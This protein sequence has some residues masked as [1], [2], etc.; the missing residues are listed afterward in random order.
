MAPLIVGYLAPSLDTTISAIGS[1]VWLLARYPAQWAAL[2]SHPALVPN[3]FNETL[4]LESP[5]RAFSRVTTVTARAGDVDIP[6]GARVVVLYASAN[7]DKRH[8]PHPDEF[9]IT[10]PNAGEH[11]GFG[12]GVHGCAGQGLARMEAHALL[13]ALAEQIDRIDLTAPATAV[14]NNL[15]NARASVPVTVTGTNHRHR[16]RRRPGSGPDALISP[17]TP[18]VGCCARPGYAG[19][20]G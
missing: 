20:G 1:A 5:L 15:I 14:L 9:D 4:R 6:A 18:P 17:P 7:R 13:T 16:A 2:R 19:A 11:L 12:W 8:F 3:V 10:R